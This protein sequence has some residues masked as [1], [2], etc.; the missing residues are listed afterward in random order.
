MA[1][2]PPLRPALLRVIEE[3]LGSLS[4][5]YKSLLTGKTLGG[6]QHDD[7]PAIS[8]FLDA[9]C[10]VAEMKAAKESAW[11][12]RK[13]HLQAEAEAL[14]VS[15]NCR[16]TLRSFLERIEWSDGLAFDESATPEASLSA[17][18]RTIY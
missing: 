13:N 2:L 8:E 9:H 15:A 11:E 17:V 4:G 12:Q 18:T 1:V 14:Q 5:V 3:Q 10:Q 6:A 16:D 7:E